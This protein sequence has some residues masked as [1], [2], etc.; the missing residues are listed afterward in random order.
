[1]LDRM[2]LYGGRL[3]IEKNRPG[4]DGKIPLALA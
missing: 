4:A 3:V 2:T 1:M